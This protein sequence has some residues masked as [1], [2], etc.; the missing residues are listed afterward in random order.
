MKK[1]IYVATLQ[2]DAENEEDAEAMME[3]YLAN[4]DTDS[5]LYSPDSWALDALSGEETDG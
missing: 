1:F 5:S 4:G 2:F 3:E